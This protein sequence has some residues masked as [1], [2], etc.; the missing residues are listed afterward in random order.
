[1]FIIP[2]DQPT[3]MRYGEQHMGII[4]KIVGGTIG[5]ALGGPLGA[6]AGAV[7]GHAF[8]HGNLALEEDNHRYLSGLEESQL[9]FFVSTFSM[10]AK[11][12]KADGQVNEKEINTVMAF[13]GQDLG[14]SAASREI[15]FNIFHA[16][17]ASPASFEDFA[18]QFNNQFQHKPQMSEMMIDI[19]L[20]VSVADGAV[21]V[22]EET[23]ILSAVNI[24]H[25]PKERYTQLK[26]QYMA[27]SDQAY[28][29]LG[30]KRDDN[31]DHI[32]KQYR[33]LVQTY[34]PDKIASKGLPEEFTQLAQEK[35]R[36]I[37]SAY[38]SIKKER[39][40]K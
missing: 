28:D 16:A 35:F 29:V 9:A 23:L 11:L 14:L 17:L 31:D 34:H 12:T 7:F 26:S 20:R 5:F 22:S 21:T 19:L 37:Q 2:W 4:G 36:E 33:H 18:V 3:A 15:A 38:E 39:G 10:L 6:I 25:M 24:F 40:F 1:M 30:C 8:D 32:K 27:N 13:A